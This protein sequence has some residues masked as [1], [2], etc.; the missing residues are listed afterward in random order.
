MT[1]TQ[2]YAEQEKRIASTAR[3]RTFSPKKSK[4][5]STNS[6]TTP[7]TP[8]KKGAIRN[9]TVC[10]PARPSPTI[11]K[12]RRPISTGKKS[13]RPAKRATPIWRGNRSPILTSNFLQKFISVP[14]WPECRYFSKK[15]S[16]SRRKGT[17]CMVLRISWPT[18]EDCWDCSWASRFFRSS[19]S[20]T[21]CL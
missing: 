20:S 11:P 4:A 10:P 14:K 15:R 8:K 19:K 18:A 9:A 1:N 12:I 21:S 5:T 2:K 3:K 7:K 16:L 17:N 13:S 6:R